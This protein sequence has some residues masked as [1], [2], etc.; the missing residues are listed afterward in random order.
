MSYQF[1]LIF[2]LMASGKEILAD[3]NDGKIK[4]EEER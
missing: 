4:K 2:D 3:D 1:R